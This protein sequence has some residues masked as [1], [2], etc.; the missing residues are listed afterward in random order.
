VGAQVC[1]CCIRRQQLLLQE[2]ET[3][4]ALGACCGRESCA[5]RLDDMLCR[6]DMLLSQ[7]W[8]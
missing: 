8:H 5:V 6:Q 2:T 3:H 1:S 7:C 4:V